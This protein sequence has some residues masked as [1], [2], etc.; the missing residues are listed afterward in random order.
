MLKKTF[1]SIRQDVTDGLTQVAQRS[2]LAVQELI[3]QP[4][5]AYEL[6]TR[7]YET[8][9]N[10]KNSQ[11]EKKEI[12]IE[13]FKHIHL[14]KSEK[15]FDAYL[16][17]PRQATKQVIRFFR[18][19][20]QKETEALN[21]F[22]RLALIL[23]ELDIQSLYNAGVVQ[24]VLNSARKEQ[25]WSSAHIAVDVSIKAVLSV[26]SPPTKR[27]DYGDGDSLGRTPLHLAVAQ[28]KREMFEH[29]L[30]IGAKTTAQD[31]EGCTIYHYILRDP[32]EGYPWFQYLI[33]EAPIERPDPAMNILNN[34]GQNPLHKAT[35]EGKDK[36]FHGLLDAGAQPCVSS[37][38]DK[39]L[40]YDDDEINACD[41]KY[42]GTP[43]HWSRTKE[44]IRL[45][46]KKGALVNAV[47]ADKS[48][49]LHVMIKKQRTEAAYE[50]VLH[51]ADVNAVG[52]NGNTPL[53]F[54]VLSG[55]LQ[56]IKA[57]ILFGANY[58]MKNDDKK[59]PGLVALESKE[60]SKEEIL[61]ALHEVGA[62]VVEPE[63]P[64]PQKAKEKEFL[65]PSNINSSSGDINHN[66]SYSLTVSRSESC[67]SV[68]SSVSAHEAPLRAKSMDEIE[69][70]KEAKSSRHNLRKNLR[71]LSLDGGGIRGL[72]LTQLLI[73]IEQEAGR[74][75]HTLFDYLVGT[76]T[77]GM[78]ALGLMQKYRATDIQRFYLKLKDD[79]FHGKRPYH[80]APLESAL[81]ELY[82]QQKMLDINEPR[83]LVTS[84]LADRQP[85]E[86][87]WFRNFIPAGK[88]DNFLPKTTDGEHKFEPTIEHRNDEVWKAARCTGAAPTFFPAMGRFLDGGLAA[89]NPTIDA[90]VE[91]IREVNEYNKTPE[92][93]DT[94]KESIKIVVSLGTGNQPVVKSRATDRIWPTNALEAYKSLTATVELAKMFVD[95]VCECDRWVVRRA[96]SF[97]DALGTAYYRLNPQ[98]SA[99]IQLDETDNT[100]LFQL[101]WDTRKYINKNKD[102]IKEM[103]C[104]L[105]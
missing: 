16:Q 92:S 36:F 49:P 55:N 24:L 40:S 81:Q 97:C 46:T 65:H 9:L 67:R 95:T 12:V 41:E 80:E 99:D 20:L 10:I 91:I 78:A 105:L 57:L 14:I 48:T 79:C 21:E 98:M 90:L 27:L 89:N 2:V 43:L 3:N 29:L 31:S 39:V 11:T 84:M 72:V 61:V 82:G 63:S 85:A 23:Y 71:I 25:G 44:D 94:G 96:Q 33:D 104:Q 73:A 26:N 53:H 87:F 19:P 32:D 47:S 4:Y 64:I 70:L 34:E 38:T 101:M 45:L 62:M 30:A 68:K 59:T 76:S 15:W 37:A 77:G 58:Q 102:Y 60:S 75:I 54:A 13:S 74:P 1:D 93:D 69:D 17:N 7:E 66:N 100:K 5:T 50:L 28:N 51:S 18:L 103:V 86:L 35:I 6:G 42:G 8:F 83:V 52:E 22:S 88:V 56:L